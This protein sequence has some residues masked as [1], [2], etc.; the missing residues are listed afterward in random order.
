MNSE[1]KALDL[2]TRI[3]TNMRDAGMSCLAAIDYLDE[4]LKMIDEKDIDSDMKSKINELAKM[5]E[6]LEQ[7]SC[8]KDIKICEA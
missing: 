2:M 6:G 3:E 4:L 7:M 5:R 8:L 1:E